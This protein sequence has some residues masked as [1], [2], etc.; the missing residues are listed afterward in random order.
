MEFAAKT[1]LRAKNIF[2]AGTRMNTCF[3]PYFQPHKIILAVYCGIAG[4]YMLDIVQKL[5]ALQG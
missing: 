2:Q 4:V 1:S 3:Q 5:V